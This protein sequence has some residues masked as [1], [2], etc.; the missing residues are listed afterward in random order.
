MTQTLENYFSI[1]AESH[2]HPR[3]KQLHLICI[4][5]IFYTVIALSAAMAIPD[6][7]LPELLRDF[8][9]RRGLAIWNLGT[10]VSILGLIFYFRHSVKYFLIMCFAVAA[11]WWLAL[12]LKTAFPNWHIY[13]NI[14]I[15]VVAWIGQFVGHGIEGKRPSFYHDLLFLLVGPLWVIKWFEERWLQ[16]KA[17]RSH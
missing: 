8:S 9:V 17:S 13:I 6:A 10:V 2:S 11:C 14:F 4:P 5:L 15:F 7:V 1:Y 3:N 12:S 16:T